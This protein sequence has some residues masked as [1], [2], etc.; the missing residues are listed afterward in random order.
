MKQKNRCFFANVVAQTERGVCQT[1][2]QN[3]QESLPVKI[4]SHRNSYLLLYLTA[5]AFKIPKWK[6]LKIR[7]SS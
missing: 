3:C 2:T 5:T 1:T 6:Q 7:T 4:L